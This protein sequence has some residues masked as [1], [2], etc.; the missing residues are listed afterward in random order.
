VSQAP[1]DVDDALFGLHAGTTG[2]RRANA[3]AA[4]SRRTSPTIGQLL[5]SRRGVGVEG[6]A[7]F[8]AALLRRDILRWC[9]VSPAWPKL[10]EGEGWLTAL[11]DFRNW[12]IQAA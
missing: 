4:R 5:Q 8:A 3:N 9:G 1:E 2:T 11:D 12:L 7:A 10:A 6:T